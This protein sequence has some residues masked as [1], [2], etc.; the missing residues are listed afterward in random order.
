M[1]LPSNPETTPFTRWSC[2]FE[3][4]PNAEY[5]RTRNKN[6]LIAEFGFGEVKIV[7]VAEFKVR[8][9]RNRFFT[10]NRLFTILSC[11]CSEL[12]KYFNKD[13]IGCFKI[14]GIDRLEMSLCL[15]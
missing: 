1:G 7:L 14:V 2:A 5:R 6:F 8:I 11:S 10:R 15:S 9:R 4:Y 13:S 3:L 12:K